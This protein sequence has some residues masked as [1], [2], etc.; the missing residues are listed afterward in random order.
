M[1]AKISVVMEVDTGCRCLTC[2]RMSE[3]LVGELS[4][5]NVIG[6]IQV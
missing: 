3:N 2:F 5:Q 4:I 6:V 1:N